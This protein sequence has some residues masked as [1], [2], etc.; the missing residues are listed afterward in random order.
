MDSGNLA[1]YALLDL[2]NAQTDEAGRQAVDAQ[3][4]GRFGAVR[5]VLIGDMSG[6]SR[7][8]QDLGILHFLA[9]IRRMQALLLPVVE[10]HGQL[11]KWEADNIYA[12]FPDASAAV[13]AAVD[14]MQACGDYNETVDPEWEIGMSFGIGY[15]EVLD[16]D[17]HDYYGD[18][19]NL[20]SKLGED[21]ANRGEVLITQ[22]AADSATLPHGRF[23]EEHSVRISG[24]SLPYYSLELV[25]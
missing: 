11:T 9:L 25:K 12:S 20:A 18:E 13:Q 14:M 21:L 17:G 19:V 23:L 6:F 2:R 3:I 7:L 16:L 5:A 1:L 24:L 8:T 22:A 15:G 10:R 4:R